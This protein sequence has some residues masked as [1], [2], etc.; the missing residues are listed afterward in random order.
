MNHPTYAC[1]AWQG[2]KRSSRELL[3]SNLVQPGSQYGPDGVGIGHTLSFPNAGD[4]LLYGVHFRPST[5]AQL[6][7]FEAPLGIVD[8]P[9]QIQAFLMTDS[10]G[11]PGS[12]IESYG[13]SNLP[14]PPSPFPLV[15]VPS[16]LDPVLIA[17][18]QYWFVAT[19]GPNTFGLWD[20]TLFQGDG[21][22]GGASRSVLGG[23]DQ[24]WIVGSGTRT[25]ALEVF[26]SSVPEPSYTVLIGSVL[27][28][29]RVGR[30]H[31]R[32]GAGP[33]KTSESRS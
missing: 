13:R 7:M 26:G 19:G 9:N 1:A 17:G 2:R 27:L 14:G 30:F 18:Q 25:G 16:S 28:F 12:V 3:F 5:T 29:L 6:T 31:H 33:R 11:A 4:Y 24:P 21:A 8:G 23:I 10:G 32:N 22:D 15:T 20:L